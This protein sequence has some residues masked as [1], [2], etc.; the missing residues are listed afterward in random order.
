[1]SKARSVT[2]AQILASRNQMI[3]GGAVSGNDLVLSKYDGSTINA[4]AVRGDP[5]PPSPT[6]RFFSAASASVQSIPT[7]TYT[8]V[9]GWALDDGDNTLVT[10]SSGTNFTLNASGCYIVNFSVFFNTNATG[11]RIVFIF[12]N[13]VEQRRVDVGSSQHSLI[14]VEHMQMLTSGDILTFRV[15]QTSGVALTLIGT[16]TPGHDVDIMK[17]F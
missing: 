17:V 15:Y 1:M 8:V 10:I 3:V 2:S 6:P 7:S 13:G 14:E 11:R 4:G 9:N 5:G 16:S 12:R